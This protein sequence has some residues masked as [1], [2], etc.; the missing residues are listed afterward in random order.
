M[1][2]A[3]TKRVTRRTEVTVR[4]GSKRRPLVVTIYPGGYF[5][6]RPAKCHKEE[7]IGF[8]EVYSMAVKMRVASERATKARNR[9]SKL[10]L[11]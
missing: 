3:L 7:T 2:T 4:D 1:A 9:K 6:L 10:K 11:Y 5:G 8:E